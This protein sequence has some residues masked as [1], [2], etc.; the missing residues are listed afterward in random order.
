MSI[1]NRWLDKEERARQCKNKIALVGKL[2]KS[3]RIQDP[4]TFKALLMP[5]LHGQE[6]SF[7]FRER[8][9]RRNIVA[10][11][12]VLAIWL[13]IKKWHGIEV[14]LEPMKAHL[15]VDHIEANHPDGFDFIYLDMYSQLNF[16][17]R[18][19]LHKIFAF[20]MPRPGCKLL[21]NYGKNRTTPEAKEMNEMLARGS[22]LG[23]IPTEV[24]VCSALEITGHPKP[25]YIKPH[26]YTSLIDGDVPRQYMTLEVQF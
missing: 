13:K 21:L 12:E 26:P 9:R 25:K 14:G 4:T 10:I 7:L 6:L 11:E 17:D 2:L 5:C 19:L 8:V 18:T 23:P 22:D 24:D 20:R 3:L 15:A 16:S 1:H